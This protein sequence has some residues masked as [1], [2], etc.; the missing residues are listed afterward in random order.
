[1]ENI[2]NKH[3]SVPAG[4]GS[5]LTR[6]FSWL[7]KS[8]SNS[9][10]KTLQNAIDQRQI[11]PFY[12]PFIN[13]ITGE[14]AGVEVLAR[15]KHPS[16]GYVSPD[17]FIPLAEKHNLI[18]PLTHSLIQQVIADLQHQIHRFPVGTYICINIS[19]QNCLDPSFEVDTCELLQKFTANQSHVVMEIT[20]RDPLHFTPELSDWF[21]AL[22]RSDISVALDDFGTGYSNLS[23]ISAL[24]PEFIKIDKMFVSQ[25]GVSDDTRLVDSLIDLAKNMRLKIIAE[26]VETQ[27]QAD[28]LR[29]KK[30]DF[31]QGFYFCKPLPVQE[32]MRVVMAQALPPH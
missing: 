31:M 15:W 12:Q 18:I 14:I 2:L 10:L 5:I 11:T 8:G 19:A 16:Y 27:V 24:N 21:A 30:I 4:R 20:E 1:M 25:I 13:G 22:R 28:Y 23:Y 17:V 9:P 3:H 7:K 6:T 29:A 32:L 26:G